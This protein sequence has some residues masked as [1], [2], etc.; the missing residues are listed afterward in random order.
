MKKE[1]SIQGIT[2]KEFLSKAKKY[3]NTI[4]KEE[5]MSDLK[6]QADI[7]VGF[8]HKDNPKAYKREYARLKRLQDP[9]AARVIDRASHEKNKVHRNKSKRDYNEKHKDAIKEKN[10]KD[11][12]LLNKA[13]NKY[14]KNNPEKQ[15]AHKV[16]ASLKKQPCEVCGEKKD[17]HRHHENYNKPAGV[18][19]LCR[20]CHNQLHIFKRYIGD[21]L[22]PNLSALE[23]MRDAK[24]ILS[25]VEM[26]EGKLKT[27]LHIETLEIKLA[28]ALKENKELRKKIKELEDEISR[29]NSL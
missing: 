10:S 17:I 18:I 25:K 29:K 28:K 15:K 22:K 9:E 2:A 20:K 11:R 14:Q 24:L 16:A 23:A 1:K 8:S 12:T 13:S 4:T 26:P 27:K 19:W 7:E 6:V 5:F 21:K 3:L